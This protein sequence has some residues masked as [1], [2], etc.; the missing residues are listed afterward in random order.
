M[1]IRAIVTGASG[2]VGEGVLHECLNDNDVE[3]V[4]VIG[5]RPCGTTHPKM[6]EVIHNNFFELS[7]VEDK[8]IGYNA[9]FFCLGVSSVGMKEPEYTQLT[10]D[11]TLKFASTVVKS[12]PDMVFCYVSGAST[13]STEKGR[14]MWARVK[15]RTENDLSKLPFKKAYM[16]RPGFMHP[17]PGLKNTLK[18]YKYILWMYPLLKI[19]FPG[20]VSTL[21][22]LGLAMI[23]AVRKGYSK[24][25]LEVDDIKILAGT[26]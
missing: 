3:Q 17:T 2:M 25:I 13:D 4:L 8:L 19:V 11:L 14:M 26:D 9:C 10:Y 5:R 21:K 16:F 22:A 23:N 20:K 24:S 18:Y 1:K 12:N 15:G 6:V 7:A